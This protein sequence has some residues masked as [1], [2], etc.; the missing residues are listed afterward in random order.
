MEDNVEQALQ[1]GAVKTPGFATE[2]FML[3]PLSPL[4]SRML[5]EVLLQDETLREQVPWIAVKHPGRAMSGARLVEQK[6][7]CGQFKVWSITR[8]APYVDVGAVVARNTPDGIDVEVMLDP[9]FD[10]DDALDE[11]FAPVLAW[12]DL[13]SEQ[14]WRAA[15]LH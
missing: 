12:L 1:D 15:R 14:L 10:A 5:F 13:R 2:H 9:R 11:V 7:A 3:L 8:R 6:T 4:E